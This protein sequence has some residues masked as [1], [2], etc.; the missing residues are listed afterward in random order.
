MNWQLLESLKHTELCIYR[1]WIGHEKIVY[2]PT[3]RTKLQTI[4]IVIWWNKYCSRF[5][6]TQIYRNFHKHCEKI[7]EQTELT[8]IRLLLKFYTVCQST[9][10]SVTLSDVIVTICL[11]FRTITATRSCDAIFRLITNFPTSPEQTNQIRQQMKYLWD[12]P[13][14]CC[15]VR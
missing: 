13:Q 2:A 10:I 9:G 5:Y 12:T 15:F 3:M 6:W 1:K 14:C 8:L 11:C 7:P 4:C